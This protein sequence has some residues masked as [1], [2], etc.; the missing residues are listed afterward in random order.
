MSIMNII[1]RIATVMGPK[2]EDAPLVHATQVECEDLGSF[3]GWGPTV[4]DIVLSEQKRP[5]AFT[6]DDG[7]LRCVIRACERIQ[8]E[9]L[10]RNNL[11]ISINQILRIERSASGHSDYASQIAFHCHEIEKGLLGQA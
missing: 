2:V 4:L 6:V 11:E 8:A 5:D 1:A 3:G 7:E 9:F 10:R